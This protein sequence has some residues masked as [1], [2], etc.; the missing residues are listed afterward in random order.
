MLRNAQA[1]YERRANQRADQPEKVE[2]QSITGSELRTGGH[3]E[4]TVDSL[5]LGSGH[6]ARC[7]APKS[8]KIEVP[9]T[10]D[11]HQKATVGTHLRFR[12]VNRVGGY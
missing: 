7:V 4:P 12:N 11:C 6:E 2:R 8:L 10:Q 9:I 5:Q 3:T 1:G